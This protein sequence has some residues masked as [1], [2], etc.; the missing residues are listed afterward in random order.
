MTLEQ[1]RGFNQDDWLVIEAFPHNSKLTAYRA[2]SNT[3]TLG[4]TRLSEVYNAAGV[5]LVG[6]IG[7]PGDRGS[8]LF[9]EDLDN[10]GS[11][12]GFATEISGQFAYIPVSFGYPLIAAANSNSFITSILFWGGFDPNVVKPVGANYI[13]YPGHDTLLGTKTGDILLASDFFNNIYG[14]DGS[15]LIFGDD[16]NNKLFGGLRNEFCWV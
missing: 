5:G 8:N 16:T 2:A 9:A 11:L 13:F 10:W 4:A 1:V 7:T 14:G 6:N 12:R 3:V 15:D